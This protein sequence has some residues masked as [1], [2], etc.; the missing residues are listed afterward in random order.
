MVLSRPLKKFSVAAAL[1]ISEFQGAHRP[2]KPGK[3]EEFAQ[4]G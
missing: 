1:T 4:S 3:L 2:F